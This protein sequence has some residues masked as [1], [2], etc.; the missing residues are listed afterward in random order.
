MEGS[1]EKSR[2][3]LFQSLKSPPLHGT[4]N[5]LALTLLILMAQ[6]LSNIALG[7]DSN[8][9]KLVGSLYDRCNITMSQ[10]IELLSL[11]FYDKPDS[12]RSDTFIWSILPPLDD[13]LRS[14]NLN[15]PVAFALAQPA[16]RML[17]EWNV[18]G[19]ELQKHRDKDSLKDLLSK[20]TRKLFSQSWSEL[21]PRTCGSTCRRTYILRFGVILSTIYTAQVNAMKRKWRS[22]AKT[23]R[24]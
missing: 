15:A 13:L 22:F 7:A 9:L 1:I 4:K 23:F 18:E 14:H 10:L 6:Q 8:Q 12:P 16:F 21:S 17:R 24:V 2:R 5:P 11:K 20:W 19:I 3:Y